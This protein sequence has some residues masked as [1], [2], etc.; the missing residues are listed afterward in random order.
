VPGAEP[1]VPLAV[2]LRGPVSDAAD[3]SP[4]DVPAADVPVPAPD[5][6]A[7][8]ELVSEALRDVRL[9]RARL[10]DALE[11]ATA[12][13]VRELAHAVLGRELILAPADLA[14]LAERILAE[15]PAATPVAIRHAPGEGTGLPLPAVADPELA[16]GDL[17]V[18]FGAGAVD[19]R[20]GVR[21]AVALE[22][23]S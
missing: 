21:L 17:I 18:T 2:W 1:F 9:F 23:W 13:L 10:A 12:R 19:A 3:E 7:V 11:A 15:H 5:P 20:L 8:P 14:A 6:V 16:P 22:A 4:A